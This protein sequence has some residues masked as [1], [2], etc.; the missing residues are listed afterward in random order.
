MK[1]KIDSFVTAN[2]VKGATKD[3]PKMAKITEV[4]FIEKEFLPFK[5]EEGRYELA[6]EIDGDTLDWMPNKTSLRT[7]TAKYGD[8]SDSWIGKEVGLFAL[9]QNVSGEMKEVIY[10]A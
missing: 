5:S 1:I 6:V 4:K 2:S 8:E 9:T 3:A 10:T 7:I